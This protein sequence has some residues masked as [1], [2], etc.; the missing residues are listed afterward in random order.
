MSVHLGHK[1][2]NKKQP[3]V[4]P[5]LIINE[6]ELTKPKR[7]EKPVGK[8]FKIEIDHSQRNSKRHISVFKLRDS[9]PCEQPNTDEQQK[10]LLDESNMLVKLTDAIV[11]R[12]RPKVEEG[13]EEQAP[14]LLDEKE[15]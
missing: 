12:P 1:E 8:V 11:F 7:Y 14:P 3:F 15:F 10:Q 5:K 4:G 9:L 13:Q 6:E 2:T